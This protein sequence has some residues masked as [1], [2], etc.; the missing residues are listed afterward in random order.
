M[1]NHL[2]SNFRTSSITLFNFIVYISV[3][4]IGFSVDYFFLSFFFLD[5]L[6]PIFGTGVLIYI[7]KYRFYSI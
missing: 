3:G 7:D 2:V 4:H 6:F 5:F 1:L